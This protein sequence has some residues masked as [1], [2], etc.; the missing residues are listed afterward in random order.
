[1]WTDYGFPHSSVGKESTCNVR[2]P[3]SIPGQ[4][5]FT[6]E[7]IDYRLYSQRKATYTLDG[8]GLNELKNKTDETYGKYTA[9]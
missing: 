7:G 1:M 4:G 6:G 8:R 2:D 3:G 5:R 9:K